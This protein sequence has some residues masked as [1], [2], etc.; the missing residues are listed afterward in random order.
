[1]FVRILIRFLFFVPF[2][3]INGDTGDRG[4]NSEIAAETFGGPD[5]VSVHLGHV[6]NA[7]QSNYR[8]LRRRQQYET[9]KIGE[10]ANVSASLKSEFPR[11]TDPTNSSDNVHR[12]SAED[13]V[14]AKN[15]DSYD[16]EGNKNSEKILSRRR[17]YLIFPP[18]SSVQI[19]MFLNCL[20]CLRFKVR[21]WPYNLSKMRNEPKI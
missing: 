14:A 6:E 12:N 18:G 16:I 1:M 11:L 3:L 8:R 19:G 21:R 10:A 15:Y 13:I 20:H 5:V 9:P 17:R 7:K 4:Y 2:I